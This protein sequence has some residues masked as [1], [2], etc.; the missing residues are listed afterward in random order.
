MSVTRDPR[1]GVV[2][3]VASRTAPTAHQLLARAG[4]RQLDDGRFTLDQ[5]DGSA[6]ALVR[7]TV[8]AMRS[9]GVTV[10]AVPEFDVP[11]ALV[12]PALAAAGPGAT[13]EAAPAPVRRHDV[14][15]GRHPRLGIVAAPA[16]ADPA[17]A[18]ALADAGFVAGQGRLLALHPDVADPARHAG[19]TIARLRSQGITVAADLTFEPLDQPYRATDAYAAELIA[20]MD[21]AP[22]SVQEP[23]AVGVDERR[24]DALVHDRVAMMAA[25]GSQLRSLDSQLR[26][27]PGSLDLVSVEAVLDEASTILAGAG[28]DLA[29]AGADLAPSRAS[30]TSSPRALAARATSGR[31]ATSAAQAATAANVAAAAVPARDPRIAWAAGTAHS[32]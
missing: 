32:R 21:R 7:H 4:F 31:I 24:A 5:V 2:A 20:A 6:V 3:E 27:D 28:T 29:R 22:G 1:Y 17:L 25:I 23:A 15:I 18:K 26:T 10:E 30:A 19:E 13:V 9:G 8:A 11:A 16:H 14:A 12:S